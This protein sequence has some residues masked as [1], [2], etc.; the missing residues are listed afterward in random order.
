MRLRTSFKDMVWSSRKLQM[1]SQLGFAPYDRNRIMRTEQTCILSTSNITAVYI[2]AFAVAAVVIGL[3]LK[4]LCWE[5][6][7]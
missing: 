2:I 4:T 6:R 3:I 7:R 1:A 5:A